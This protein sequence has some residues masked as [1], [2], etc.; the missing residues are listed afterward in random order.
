MK[1]LKALVIDTS[2]V[3]TMVVSNVD[4]NK[5]I[6]ILSSHDEHS[7]TGR[8]TCVRKG[9]SYAANVPSREEP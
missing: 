6:Q 2:D 7:W 5:L 4:K 8:T 3:L 9:E 1:P